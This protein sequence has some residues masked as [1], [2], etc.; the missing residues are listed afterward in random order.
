M[1]RAHIF[2][3]QDWWV[4]LAATLGAFAM[5]AYTAA[6][7]VTLLDSGEF[8]VA[9][10]HFGV[11]HPTGYPLWTLLSWIFQL[12]PLGNGSWEVALF[13]GVCAALAVGICGLLSS[14]MLGAL[15]PKEARGAVRWVRPGVALAFAL[16]LAFSVSM[17]SQAVIA[18]VYGLHALLIGVY[19]ML[20]YCW[21]HQP[22]RDG[23]MLGAFFTLALSFSNHH[24]TLVMS[25]LPFVLIVL[26]RR[27]AFW[28]WVMASVVTVLLVYLGF[29]LLG[30]DMLVLR[31]AIRFF[32]CTGVALGV[33]LW[34][35]RMRIRWKL[36]AFLPFAVIF[37]LL[38]YYYMPFAS[39]TNPPMNW[40][41]TRDME[42]FYYSVN[43]SQYN[44]S[45]SEQSIKTLGRLMGTY[46][47]KPP[48]PEK[49]P[50]EISKRTEFQLWAGF[51]WQ[52]LIRSFTVLAV[53]AYL[54]SLLAVMRLPLARRAWI[55][56]LHISFVLA[57]FLQPLMDE[58][59]I[60]QAGWWI[61]MPYHT[62][63][64]LIFAVLC[65]FGM[66][67]MIYR[68]A[69]R[70]G[71]LA[72]VAPALLALPVYTATMNYAECSQRGHW[73]GWMFGR[74]MLKDL[75]PG[76]VMIGGTD[77][78]RFVPTYMIFGE[79]PQAG[80]HKRD[81]DFDRRDLYI[82]T[83]NA[84]G[85]KNYMR[86]LRD[87]YTTARP[88]PEGAFEKWLGREKTYPEKPLIFPT[89]E[90]TAE[91]AKK[92]E[93]DAVKEK[94]PLER[95]MT[96]SYGEVLKWLWEKN[97]D[98]HTFFVE[99]SFPIPWTYDYAI[100]HGLVYELGKTKQDKLPP[101]VVERDFAY[102]KEY[103]AR[104]MADP[105]YW[106]DYDAQRSFSKLRQS[107][108]NI[109]R[110]KK[111]T[112][113]AERAYYEALELWPENGEVIAILTRMLWE[114]GD[115][116]TAIHLFDR[117]LKKDPNNLDLWKL[118]IFA[119][120]R[121]ELEG[122][123]RALQE[124]LARQ[125]KSHET[126][127]KLVSLY[128]QAGDMDKATE[129]VERATRELPDNAD[130]LRAAVDFHTQAGDL[131]RTLEAA[132]RLTEIESS[133]ARNYLLLARAYYAHDEKKAFYATARKALEIGG[134]P[135]RDELVNDPLYTPWRSDAEF[136]A[137]E[138]PGQ[139]LPAPQPASS[140]TVGQEQK[141]L[142]SP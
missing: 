51:F 45:L 41:H 92:A 62:Y 95:V 68:L 42:G 137:I 111:M 19:L 125:P 23:F 70:R 135:I 6:P 75:P 54:V 97:R 2:K 113:E 108:A 12:L 127:I 99:E 140:P 71:A 132:K 115:Y 15:E 122:E 5:Y 29:A 117:A 126:I 39:G 102:W 83:Q 66:G 96:A 55:Y 94:L 47:G 10:M 59:R 31:T 88:K 103:K 36:L 56:M 105:L 141:I 64:N 32:Y 65:A 40:S 57:A 74:D 27:R 124:Q 33:F 3:A 81:P 69:K 17:W 129:L 53:P 118:R 93:E 11:P 119:E 100:P 16:L 78:G 128:M 44:G 114:K 61:Q 80:K 123:I 91:M 28:D 37:G 87:Q 109:Y 1:K 116:Q 136:R 139:P 120:K 76:S 84:L 72:W 43:R 98:E 121:Q 21:T 79:S 131:T 34:L 30:K 50:G 67:F 4:A 9:A 8:L 133:N 49:E 52:Q 77:P 22:N 60:D 58:V 89:E 38:P 20:L 48:E 35:R 85:E 104:L 18:E 7:N 90:E 107:I 13:S 130:M 86:Y 25:P 138:T 26:L 73:F 46:P 142:R 82:I 106:Q 134:L 63:T 24:L 110:H 112:A 14:N 101:E